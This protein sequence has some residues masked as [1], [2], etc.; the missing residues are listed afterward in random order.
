MANALLNASN[1]Y[2][3]AN[4]GPDQTI[5]ATSPSGVSFSIHGTGATETGIPSHSS[6][7]VRQPCRGPASHSTCPTRGAE[8]VADLHHDVDRE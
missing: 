7:Q 1:R 6:G 3:S 5:E 8:H 2:P 4:A